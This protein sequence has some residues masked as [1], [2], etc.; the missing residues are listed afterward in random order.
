MEAAAN[1]NGAEGN[2]RYGCDIVSNAIMAYVYSEMGANEVMSLILI[3]YFRL[4][5]DS[6]WNTCQII[7]SHFVFINP[8]SADRLLVRQKE[9]QCLRSIFK[10]R[11]L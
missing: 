4:E 6:K 5:S 3:S 1:N 10:M 9:K 8:I 2:M 11:R 7:W